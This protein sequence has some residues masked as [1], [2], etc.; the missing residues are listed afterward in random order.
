[1]PTHRRVAEVGTSWR[2]LRT[3]GTL[4][5]RA[6]RGGGGPM[7]Y[8]AFISYSHSADGQLAPAVQSGLQ[9]LAR[10]WYRRRALRVFRDETGLSVNPHLW[11]SIERAMDESRY[12]VL[13]ASP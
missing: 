11:G 10:P 1:M 12:F 5:P 6:G 3:G 7:A 4:G 8:D 13:L 2:I 9:R